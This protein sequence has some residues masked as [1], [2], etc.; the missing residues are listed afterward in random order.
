MSR[1]VTKSR[2][3]L[4][5]ALL[6]CALAGSLWLV[7]AAAADSSPGDYPSWEEVQDAKES[8]AGK[9]A[10]IAKIDGLLSSLQDQSEAAGSAAVQAAAEYA[11]TDAA[12]QAAASRRMS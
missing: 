1:F 6:S 5:V 4:P 7:P 11:A 3:P 10:E 2:A 12:L 8:E 9:A